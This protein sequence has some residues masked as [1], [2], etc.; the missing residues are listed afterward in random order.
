MAMLALVNRGMSGVVSLKLVG[1]GGDAL[2]I[3]A[4]SLKGV[5]INAL[6]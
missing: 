1:N 3:P 5:E 2:S 4:L 6:R